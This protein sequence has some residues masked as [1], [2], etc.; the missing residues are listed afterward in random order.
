MFEMRA[1]DEIKMLFDSKKRAIEMA[2]RFTAKG[3]E[4]VVI[5]KVNFMV[6]YVNLP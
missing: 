6:V 5:D 2:D 4:T 1:N 3:F